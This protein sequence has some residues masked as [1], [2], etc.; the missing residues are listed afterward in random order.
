MKNS[1]M[2]DLRHELLSDVAD[3]ATTVAK[4][5]GLMADIADQ[6]GCAVANR[7]A[8][9]WGG[10]LISFPKDYHF[11]TSQRDLQIYDEFTGNNHSELSRKYGLSVRAIYKVIEKTRKRDIDKR[12]VK[13]F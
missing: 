12:Q 6:V 13:L 4:D 3:L 10:Q 8:D 7:I 2:E 5:H 11:K 1:Q 9:H